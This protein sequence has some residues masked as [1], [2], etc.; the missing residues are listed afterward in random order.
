MGCHALL[1]GVF[2]TQGSNPGLP[3]CKQF[4]Y[5][6]SHQGSPKVVKD[7]T[8][9]GIAERRAH[10]APQT[11]AHSTL[12]SPALPSYR[13]AQ[14]TRHPAA[15]HQG[16]L[17]RPGTNG[18]FRGKCWEKELPG[19][20]VGG[21]SYRSRGVLQV[22]VPILRRGTLRLRQRWRS[23]DLPHLTVFHSHTG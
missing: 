2:L 14:R 9:S 12:S 5:H 4:L 18:A 6:L 11:P 15:Q 23:L 20:H 16:H 21:Q 8:L 13:P 22:L 19:A 17:L 10:P 3:H 7:A 1:Q